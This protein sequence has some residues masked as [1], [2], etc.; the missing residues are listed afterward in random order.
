MSL[1]VHLVLSLS[2]VP[3]FS[4]FRF[5]SCVCFWLLGTQRIVTYCVASP[6]I[7]YTI[8]LIDTSTSRLPF[9]YTYARHQPVGSHNFTPVKHGGLIQILCPHTFIEYYMN[10]D[11]RLVREEAMVRVH[12]SAA[13]GNCYRRHYLSKC[14]RHR[15]E[16]SSP[17][18]DFH[19]K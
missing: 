12:Y 19:S 17:Y 9:V 7:R 4:R 2:I 1:T 15:I 18:A 6:S 11:T 14:Q 13:F 3:G 10:Q 16:G 8:G 5:F